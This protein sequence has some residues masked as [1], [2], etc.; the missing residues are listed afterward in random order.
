[1]FALQTLVYEKLSYRVHNQKHIERLSKLLEEFNN[2]GVDCMA[3]R[4]EV[5]EALELFKKHSPQRIFK[6]VNKSEIG[7]LAVIKLLHEN[8]KKL[9]S[10]DL[11]KRLK[12]SSARMAVLIKRL[13]S[14]GLVEKMDS[15]TDSRSKIL[16]LSEKGVALAHKLQANMYQTMEKIVDVFGLEELD[17]LFVKFNKVRE[18][19]D[20]NAPLD[21]E[22]Y[23]G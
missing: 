7:A 1:M 6:E 12:I 3:T 21:L 23:N 10:S 11:C 2:E 5:F 15:D 13:K 18:I 4:E 17:S 9:T 8:E 20:A 16:Y 14:K 19:L 22:E